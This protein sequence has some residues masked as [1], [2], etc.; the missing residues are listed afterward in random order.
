MHSAQQPKHTADFENAEA[1]VLNRLKNELARTL[2]YHGYHHTLDVMDAAMKIADTEKLS[3]EEKKLLRIAVAFHDAGFIYKYKDHE[4]KGC[5]MAKEILP[6][7]TFNDEQIQA[8]CGMIMATKI[9]QNAANRLEQ[10]ICDADVDYLGRED[11]CEIANTLFKESRI[12]ANI[13]DEE[14]WD[15]EQIKFLKEHR[16]YTDYSIG[17]RKPEKLKY[18]DSLLKKKRTFNS[19]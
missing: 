16:Y 7:F 18:L 4:Q 8:I 12:Y 13:P 17:L 10:I 6:A 11:V 2:Y 14:K 15:E 1:Y 19:L 9:P 3:D 5:E